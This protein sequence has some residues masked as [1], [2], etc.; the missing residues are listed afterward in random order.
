MTPRITCLDAS[1][2][3]P[4]PK[5]RDA[6]VK[7]L[8]HRGLVSP[9]V[10]RKW[11]DRFW[12][13]ATRC[14]AKARAPRPPAPRLPSLPGLFSAKVRVGHQE[15][16]HGP[17]LR[18]K[19]PATMPVSTNPVQALCLFA[20]S[21]RKLPFWAKPVHLL[22][23]KPIR[24]LGT[25]LGRIVPGRGGDYWK[26]GR[27]IQEGRCREP[28]LLENVLNSQRRLPEA[29]A[30][31]GQQRKGR[32]I[33]NG[34]EEPSKQMEVRTLVWQNYSRFEKGQA[35]LQ[36]D[37]FFGM[38]KHHQG[39][40]QTTLRPGLRNDDWHGPIPANITSLPNS[41]QLRQFA[42][43]NITRKSVLSCRSRINLVST[44]APGSH[45]FTQWAVRILRS[46]FAR[47]GA[48]ATPACPRRGC[49]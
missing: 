7:D 22:W 39:R 37:F 16:C 34:L 13:L 20:P 1:T 12:I 5:A 9:Q 19:V 4:K 6:R 17:D 14:I 31:K 35:E 27:L 36:V 44:Q 24:L 38:A 3:L 11:A 15:L 46:A 43:P 47:Q 33:A 26:Q 25:C 41:N 45:P 49:G 48:P 42:L 8:H 23:K 21:T 28:L 10:T 40:V 29:Q 32:N 18:K 2:L 30:P